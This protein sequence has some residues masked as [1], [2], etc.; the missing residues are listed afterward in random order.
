[1]GKIDD[2]ARDD[3]KEGQNDSKK[4]VFDTAVTDITVNHP[5]SDAYYKGRSGEPLDSDKKKD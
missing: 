5:D 1:M 3:Y 4:G 2:K